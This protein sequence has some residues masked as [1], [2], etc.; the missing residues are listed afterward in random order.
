M[1][2]QPSSTALRTG[3]RLWGERGKCTGRSLH[4]QRLR[5]PTLGREPGASRSLTNTVMPEDISQETCISYQIY[6]LRSLPKPAVLG[7]PRGAPSS[8]RCGMGCRGA[9]GAGRRPHHESFSRRQPV[10]QKRWTPPASHLHLVPA[11]PNPLC[12]LRLPTAPGSAAAQRSYPRD[13]R[14][15]LGRRSP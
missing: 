5:I 2:S 14:Q 12:L 13:P 6:R 9:A 10:L 4:G 3:V 1:Q 7:R 11:P 8:L 15:E